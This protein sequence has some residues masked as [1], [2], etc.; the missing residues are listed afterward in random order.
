ME[1]KNQCRNRTTKPRKYYVAWRKGK[2]PLLE[3]IG[4]RHRQISGDVKKKYLR[5]ARSFWNQAKQQESHPRDKRSGTPPTPSNI[6]R[7][8]LQVDE[9]RTQISWPKNKEMDDYTR[10]V[11]SKRCHRQT[12]YMCQEKKEKE[13]LLTLKIALIIS[14]KTRGLYKKEQEKINNNSQLQLWEH[15]HK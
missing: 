5:R 7:N 14:T 12:T 8:I 9:E 4:S 1:K 13:D 15:K 6:P 10:C 11:T 2:P 3:D